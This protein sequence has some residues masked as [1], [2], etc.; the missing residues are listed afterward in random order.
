MCIKY[1]EFHSNVCLPLACYNDEQFYQET[2]PEAVFCCVQTCLL[3]KQAKVICLTTYVFTQD[4][5]SALK[6]AAMKGFTKV[7]SLLLE[8]GAKTDLQDKVFTG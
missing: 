1:T 6:M 3:Q 8:A 7:L 5:D 2:L 4:G